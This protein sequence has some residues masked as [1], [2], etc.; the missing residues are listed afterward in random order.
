MNK[1]I[2]PLKKIAAVKK[3]LDE[4]VPIDSLNEVMVGVTLELQRKGN[5]YYIVCKRKKN[6]YKFQLKKKNWMRSKRDL[7]RPCH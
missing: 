7:Q 1:N 4:F 3:D 2:K 6:I 5:S